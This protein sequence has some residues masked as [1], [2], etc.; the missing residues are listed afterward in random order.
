MRA[1]E[2]QVTIAADFYEMR[3]CARRLL[4]DRYKMKTHRYIKGRFSR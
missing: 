3:N 4:L 1:T 2:Q